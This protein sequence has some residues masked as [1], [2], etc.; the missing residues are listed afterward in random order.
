M[1]CVLAVLQRTGLT[2]SISTMEHKGNVFPLGDRG[3]V[4]FAVCRSVCLFCG[5]IGSDM[6]I[7]PPSVS[8]RGSDGQGVISLD[9]SLQSVRL[10]SFFYVAGTVHFGVL[11]GPSPRVGDVSGVV[12]RGGLH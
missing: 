3:H 5:L 11:A 7:S 12:R 2:A 9:R 8:S 4:L 1:F 10:C 6:D